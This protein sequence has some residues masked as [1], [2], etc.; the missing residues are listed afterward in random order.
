[1]RDKLAASFY[2]SLYP[3]NQIPQLTQ[4]TLNFIGQVIN[5]AVTKSLEGAVNEIHNQI[6]GQ[7]YCQ[8]V[9]EF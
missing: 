4:G 3:E 1:M 5:S 6:F 8:P 2:Q 7:D 9:I